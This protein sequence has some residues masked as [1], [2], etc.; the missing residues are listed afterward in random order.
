[1]AALEGID[2]SPTTHPAR[3][4]SLPAAVI[5]RYNCLYQAGLNGTIAYQPMYSAASLSPYPSSASGATS[6]TGAAPVTVGQC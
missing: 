1:M 2:T 3:A 6:L 5:V 4:Y